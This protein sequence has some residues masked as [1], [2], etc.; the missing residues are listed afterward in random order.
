LLARMKQ[1]ETSRSE[2]QYLI[3]VVIRKVRQVY[4]L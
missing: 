1:K 3:G 2:L 4:R